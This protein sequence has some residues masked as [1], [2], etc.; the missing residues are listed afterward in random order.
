MGQRYIRKIFSSVTSVTLTH[1][2]HYFSKC[3]FF[4]NK[5]V[6][7]IVGGIKWVYLVFSKG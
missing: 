7:F 1:K 3:V 4:E 5:I 2:K 6:G